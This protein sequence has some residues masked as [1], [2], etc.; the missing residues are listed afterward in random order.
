[1]PGGLAARVAGWQKR[2][3]T[4]PGVSTPAGTPAMLPFPQTPLDLA[5]AIW[6]D[7]SWIDITPDV[8]GGKRAEITITR[9][10]ANEG[11]RVDPS[12]ATLQLNN[13]NGQYSPRNPTSWLYGKIGRNTL[14]RV[15]I[16]ADVRFS[17][18]IS[19][20]PQRW[21]TTGTDIYVPVQASGILRRLTQGA[22]P[23]KSTMY[24]GYTA[25][26]NF[27]PNPDAA[28]VAY[29]PCEDGADSTSIASAIGGPPMTVTGTPTLASNTDFNCSAPIPVLTSSAWAGVVPAYADTGFVGV[30]MLVS[31]PAAGTTNGQVIFRLFTT[32]TVLRWDMVYVTGGTLNLKGYD[33]TGANVVN[34]SVLGLGMNGNPQRVILQ[35]QTT[36]SSNLDWELKSQHLDGTIVGS[37]GTF[38]SQTVSRALRVVVNPDLG[39]PDVAFGHVAVHKATRIV[40]DLLDEFIAWNGESAGRRIERLCDEENIGFRGVGNLDATAAMGPQLPAELVTLLGDAADADGGILYEPREVFGL[41]YRTRSSLYNQTARL[42]LDYSAAHLS[43]IEPVDDDQQT[44]ND[45]T[46]KRQNGSSAHAVQTSGPLSVAAP[47]AG[48]GRYDTEVTLNLQTDGQLADA[49]GWLLHLGTVD[50]ARYPILSVDLAR[51]P[52]A[53]QALAAACRALD[54]GDRLTVDNPPGWLPPDEISQLAQG[55]V[56]TLGNFTHRIAINCTPETP[57]GQVAVYDD[58]ASRYSSNG[59][60]L[61][62]DLTQAATSVSVATPTGRLWAYNDGDFQI[63]VGGEVMTVTAVAGTTSPQTFTVVRSV[64]AV[65]KAHSSGETLSLAHPCVYVR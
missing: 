25:I 65:V 31:I 3:G 32:G 18:E 5:V 52:F 59:S 45:I 55:F 1:M 24:R 37:S 4:W 10:K 2:L 41:A 17:G 14:V 20:W 61:A 27:L 35:L 8:Y 30:W 22:T 54:I 56:E 33:A 46:V 51:A 12:V 42:V 16:G 15:S 21:D 39:L 6:V 11:N 26:G 7:S 63:R 34:Q 53:V 47:P 43:G 40:S 58:N 13:R 23:L 50:E 9:G 44:R 38:A 19:E 64:N 57:W 49:A 60:T 48:V 29:W 62:G 36:G 28:P